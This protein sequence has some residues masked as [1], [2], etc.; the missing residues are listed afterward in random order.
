M[1][2]K[3]R[4]KNFKCFTEQEVPMENLTIL[5]G[6]NASGKSSIVQA[7]LLA[8]ETTETLK[9][10]DETQKNTFVDILKVFYNGI[11][12]PQALIS[13]NRNDDVEY[14]FSISIV[15]EEEQEYQ[16]VVE[17]ENPL[18]LKLYNEKKINK[19]KNAP[20]IS[21]LNAERIGPRLVYQAGGEEKIISDGS[22]SAY[23][24]VRAEIEKK[25]IPNELILEEGMTS[26]QKNVE[27]WLSA[28]IG[29]VRL[30]VTVDQVRAQAEIRVENEI[31]K[32]L[33]VPTMTGFGISYI[34]P[35]VVAGLWCSC[36]KNSML[37]VE[38]PEAHLH[39]EAQSQIGKFLAIL[40]NAGVQ[41]VVET[42]SEH[43]ID[44]ARVQMAYM[45]STKYMKVLFTRAQEDEI[46]VTE[47]TVDE[48]GNLSEWPVGFFDQKA[49]DLRKLFQLNRQR[50]G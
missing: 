28:I 34:L 31:S 26:F 39:P 15:G 19:W 14:D 33:V 7:I 13:N 37:I 29:E 20:N 12:T 32:E 5:A 49:L 18:N 36:E 1:I 16:Y 45:K 17:A 40:A 6:A 2:K 50:R 4:L 23:L 8:K 11:G 44:G 47:I 30:V 21:Y 10:Y 46:K 25:K 41:V 27:S 35:I 43:I 24:I 9:Y 38:N 42:H 3:I 22:N 48:A